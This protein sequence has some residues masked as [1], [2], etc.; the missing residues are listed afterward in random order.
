MNNPVATLRPN[1]TRD[2][3]RAG[4][5]VV[6]RSDRSTGVP[7]SLNGSRATVIATSSSTRRLLVRL[8]A[9]AAGRGARDLRVTP[10]QIAL[11][12]E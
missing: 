8:P 9:D 5:T 1:Y 10:N 6:L 3:F 7:L 11:I 2:D 4:Q 12:I